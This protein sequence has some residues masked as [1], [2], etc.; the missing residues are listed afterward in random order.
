MRVGKLVNILITFSMTGVGFQ[1]DWVEG[2][3]LCLRSG[4]AVPLSTRRLHLVDEDLDTVL[5]GGYLAA[6]PEAM[7]IIAWNCQG[8]GCPWIVRA[9]RELV[10][11]HNRLYFISETKSNAR[12][13]DLIKQQL[14]YF[15][16]GVDST[17]RGGGLLLWRKDVDFWVQSFSDHH[18]V[19]TIASEG[20]FNKILDLHD[21]QGVRRS[22]L[23]QMQDFDNCLDECGLSDLG[24]MGYCFTWCNN[25]VQPATIRERLDRACGDR[26]W[27]LLFPNALL[28]DI[29]GPCRIMPCW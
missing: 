16:V 27:L 1:A 28:S 29:V 13:Y 25:R 26:Q 21:K 20:D 14:N 4:P 6:S 12:R 3:G 5:C 15:A 8:L 18:I 22:A 10:K 19:T 17:G 2:G 9:L 7:K 24:F 11:L 23:W